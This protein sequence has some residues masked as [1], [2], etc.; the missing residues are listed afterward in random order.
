[1]NYRSVS[2]HYFLKLGLCAIAC[3]I[4]SLT[5]LNALA[6]EE[7]GNEVI[8]GFDSG[9]NKVALIEL[10][11]SEG[12]SSCP[13]A[14]RWLSAVGNGTA[15]WRDVVPLAFH[16]SYWDR[17]GW[18]DRFAKRQFDNRQRALAQRTDSG[19]Y[20]PGVFL[21]GREFRGWRTTPPQAISE[22]LSNSRADN[23]SS[24]A[25]GNLSLQN[26]RGSHWTVRFTPASAHTRRADR[27]YIALLGNDLSNAVT[28]GEN[29]GKQLSHDFV[30][31][32]LD[33]SAMIHSVG[34]NDGA[35]AS[36]E[37]SLEVPDLQDVPQAAIAAWVVDAAGRPVQAVGG[38][39]QTANR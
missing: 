31:L 16:V 19:V 27:A 20:T 17:L 1:M 6:T 35:I 14:D 28:R 8:K 29:R 33:N 11:T 2:P 21:D 30:V 32:Q 12:C 26:T 38:P 25:P 22:G 4:A 36:A 18:P 13:P 9:Q 7:D 34:R 3:A 24:V 23:G 39:L 37:F 10:Y 15:V 5:S